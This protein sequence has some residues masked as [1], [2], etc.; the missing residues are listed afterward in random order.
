MQ[1]QQDFKLE[2]IPIKNTYHS[3]EKHLVQILNLYNIFC[4]QIKEKEKDKEPEKEKFRDEKEK[5]RK[6]REKE[7][8]KKERE[9]ESEKEKEDE[10]EEP[11][12]ERKKKGR[13]SKVRMFSYFLFKLANLHLL[14]IGK[15]SI[16]FLSTLYNNY[17]RI[18]IMQNTMVRGEGEWSAGEKIKIRSQG[19]KMKKGKEKK[20][21]NYIK[22]G[23]K[24]L[25]NASIWA[26]NSKKMGGGVNDQN[27]QY[28][29]LLGTQY[30][31]IDLTKQLLFNNK[32]FFP[33]FLSRYIQL[34]VPT[35]VYYR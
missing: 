12:P 4:I 18:Y 8:E 14:K 23:G 20:E 30:L 21:E 2:H 29:S 19:K 10:E 24:G 27:A 3:N 28:I 11:I 7:K 1:Y 6:E 17:T 32:D 25:K 5:E 16:K 31:V 9:K 15:K 33:I 34:G 35:P 26:I 13:K 22:K